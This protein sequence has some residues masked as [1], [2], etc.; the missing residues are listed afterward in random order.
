MNENNSTSIST[1]FD[2]S[3][4]HICIYCFVSIC[5]IIFFMLTPLN[6][7]IKTSK[8]IKIITTCIL[9]YCLYLNSIQIQNL[10]ISNIGDSSDIIKR[11]LNINIICSY[12]F[13]L[14]IFLLI[15]FVIRSFWY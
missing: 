12:L 1:I 4:K 8:F 15:F 14:S 13:S 5:F 7:F 2:N 10:S 6:Q 11:H 3:T 9:A